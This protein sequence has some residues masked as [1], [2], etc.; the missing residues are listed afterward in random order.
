MS[1]PKNPDRKFYGRKITESYQK[2]AGTGG[3]PVTSDNPRSAV[4]IRAGK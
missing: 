1:R 4:Q 2:D 3:R